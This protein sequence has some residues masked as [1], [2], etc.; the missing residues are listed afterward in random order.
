MNLQTLAQPSRQRCGPACRLLTIACI[1]CS[2]PAVARADELPAATPYRPSVSTPAALS[3]PGWIEVE[4]GWQHDH[5]DD[6]RR[7]DALPYTFKLAFTPDWGLRIGG[8]AWVREVDAAGAARSGAGDTAL[9]LKRRFAVDEASAFGLELGAK[10]PTARSGLGSGA[11]DAGVNGIYSADFA[12]GW[13]TDLNFNVTRLGG[14]NAGASR[15]QQ[16]WAASLSRS[17]GERW[18]LTGELSGTRQRGADSTAQVLLAASCALS[19]S[20]VLDAGL[21]KGLNHASGDWS[22]FAGL[23][24][25]AFKLF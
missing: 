24:F 13:H 8:D 11:T 10:A 23:T 5:G 16:G 1:A 4:A 18:G 6:P 7:R 14:D 12:E 9:V 3:A 21:S 22:A 19:R 17:L 15:W 2:V 20:V 25:V